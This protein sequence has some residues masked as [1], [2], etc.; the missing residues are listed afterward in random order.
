MLAL[1]AAY[2][3][4]SEYSSTAVVVIDAPE[5]AESVDAAAAINRLSQEVLSTN[6]LMELIRTLNLYTDERSRMPAEE[7]LHLMR[8]NLRIAPAPEIEG[9]RSVAAFNVSFSYPDRFGARTVVNYLVSG[10]LHENLKLAS[11]QPE[12]GLS[13]RVLD[14]A[15]L[16]QVPSYPNRR[17]IALA[18]LA[19]G[20]MLGGL[21]AWYRRKRTCLIHEPPN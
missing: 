1:V 10:L 5:R 16:S 6:D 17:A 2:S 11:E 3:L 14:P 18:G 15:S 21:V 9:G 4:K 7:I 13:L 19:A 20:T 12:H 8:Q